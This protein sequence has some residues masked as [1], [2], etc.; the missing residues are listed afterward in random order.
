[1]L[2]IAGILIIIA[3]IYFPSKKAVKKEVNLGKRHLENLDKIDP[4]ARK[5]IQEWVVELESELDNSKLGENTLNRLIGLKISQ[6]RSTD[7][8]GKSFRELPKSLDVKNEA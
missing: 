8:L 1:M 6:S 5:V 3:L 7:E 2:V 4:F